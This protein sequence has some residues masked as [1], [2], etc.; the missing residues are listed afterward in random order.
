MVLGRTAAARVLFFLRD[1]LNDYEVRAYVGGRRDENGTLREPEGRMTASAANHS[2][3]TGGW[4][5]VLFPPGTRADKIELV[6]LGTIVFHEVEVRVG[7]GPVTAVELSG[8]GRVK[9]PGA[10][11]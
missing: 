10:A 8:W 2:R 3:M 5:E 1:I 11:P 6:A 4:T 7:D 9:A